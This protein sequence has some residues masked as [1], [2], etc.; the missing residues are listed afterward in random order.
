MGR[1]EN[2]NTTDQIIKS[3]NM[4]KKDLTTNIMLKFP[5]TKPRHSS[6]NSHFSNKIS[7]L[8][9]VPTS[10]LYFFHLYY[11]HYWTNLQMPC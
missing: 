2:T 11:H 5:N 1:Q 4:G 10:P 8:F 6:N 9:H 3:P 7:L